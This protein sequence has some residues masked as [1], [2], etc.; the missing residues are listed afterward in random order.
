[1][2]LMFERCARIKKEI[3]ELNNISE[4]HALLFKEMKKIEKDHPKIN[5]PSYRT[6]WGKT[7]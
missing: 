4:L 3:D 2:E 7:Q 6:K 5:D 1:M